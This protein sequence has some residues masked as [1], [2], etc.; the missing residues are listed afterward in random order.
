[1]GLSVADSIH[2]GLVNL[3]ANWELV[4]FQWLQAL[5]V[6][7]LAVA[8]LLPP[9]TAL[10]GVS[11][12]FLFAATHQDIST[13]M[14]QLSAW[15]A[16]GRQAWVLLLTS[17]VLA[18]AIWLI[19]LLVYCYFQGGILGVLMAGDRQAPRS[20]WRRWQWFRTY[21]VH[22]LRGWGGR[23]LWRYFWLFHLFAFFLLTWLLLIVV[24]VLLATWGQ[25]RWG[26]G[27]AL[28][29]GCGGAMPLLFGI[30]VWALWFNLAQADLARQESSVRSAT[31]HALS[32]LGGRLGAVVILFLL[33]LAAAVCLGMFAGGLSTVAAGV[34]RGSAKAELAGG[35]FV[36]AVEWFASSV[37]GVAFMSIL[38]ALMHGEVPREIAG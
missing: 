8:G 1:M 30:F 15:T 3:R 18:S 27:A 23:Y 21:S 25:A 4:F 9:Y 36:S 6:T 16:R 13:L 7:L 24:V 2:R 19:A 33:G 20:G 37:V 32:V 10:G 29:I 34:L 26:P 35:L 12:D 11:S 5:L 14:A 22:D 17:L 28:G 31:R 38:I